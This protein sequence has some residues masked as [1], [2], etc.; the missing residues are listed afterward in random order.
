[1]VWSTVMVT[2][3]LNLNANVARKVANR[4]IFDNIRHIYAALFAGNHLTVKHV[5]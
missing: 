5:R 2:P 3:K 4:Y 1:M